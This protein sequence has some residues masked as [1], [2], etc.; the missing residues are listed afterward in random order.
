[1]NQR[2]GLFGERLTVLFRAAGAP[3]TKSVVRAV[4]TRTNGATTVTEQQ[5]SK[6]R[7]ADRVP[8]TFEAVRPV[9][10]V[11][12]TAARSRS[13]VPAGLDPSLLDL[14]NWHETWAV[15]RSDG[16]AVACDPNREPYRGL[17]PY[18]AEDADLFF[19]RDAA[20]RQ[21]TDLVES[22]ATS[23]TSLVL[24]L[25]YPGTG[26]SSLLAAGLQAH[27]GSRTPILISLGTDPLA[28]LRTVPYSGDGNRLILID[29][30]EELFT[31]CADEV[32]N[33]VLDAVRGLAAANVVVLVLDVNRVPDILD[34]EPLADALPERSMVL[35]AMTE[36]ELRE[37][38]TAPAAAL[39]LRVDPHLV[40]V[41]LA[42]VHAAASPNARAAL[43][44]LL[45]H[46]LREI[47]SKRKSKT[48]TLDLYE[49]AGRVSGTIAATAER[50]WSEL[51]T[52]EREAARRLLIALTLA[53]PHTT[54]RNRVRYDVL[55]SESANPRRTAA[56]ID[57]FAAAR[58]LI[59]H[60][61]E[62]ELL[63]DALL[64]GWPRMTGWL[65]EEAKFAPARQRVEEDARAWSAGGHP[66]RL[67]YGKGRLD[68]ATEL[69][70]KT[71]SLNCVAREF[72]AESARAVAR[73]RH[74]WRLLLVGATG[75]VA[76]AVVALL[77]ALTA[78][79]ADGDE[80]C[81]PQAGAVERRQA[82]DP[83]ISAPPTFTVDRADPAGPFPR[84]RTIAVWTQTS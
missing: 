78:R 75:L 76:L 21:L 72:I 68:T 17:A 34:Y 58:L 7:R 57:R 6:W 4:N 1:M 27:P 13:G 31:R 49:A 70:A 79:H 77:L 43:L 51:D 29:Q 38:I 16:P 82:V 19:G 64:T 47:W 48:L 15:S 33:L 24:L 28:A 42:D 18:R 71:N 65:A 66:V 12:I 45:S 50:V 30:G 56:I 80:Y 67:L 55:V 35:G 25:G 26:K 40:D 46:V 44:P 23:D 63:H 81:N 11:L 41:L 20:L 52:D 83:G 32:R 69:D 10:E 3:P 54:I 60:A 37:A 9:L 53:G 74:A 84:V 8:A 39:G 14:A 59:H 36:D 61:G 22:A 62:V 5:I 2:K 73:R